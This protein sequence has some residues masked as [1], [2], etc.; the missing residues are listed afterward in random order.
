MNV[1][2]P[3]PGNPGIGSVFVTAILTIPPLITAAVPIYWIEGVPV[4]DN[5]T[6][7]LTSVAIP[8]PLIEELDAIPARPG[9]TLY[10]E[11]LLPILTAVTIPEEAKWIVAPAE[12]N[13]C[14]PNP[15]VDPT[16]II[17]P[18][19]GTDA[20]SGS[21]ATEAAAPV[22]VIDVIPETWVNS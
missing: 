1:E 6:P 4:D 9:I 14:N 8:T 7:T 12:T 22:N 19:T 21:Y 17:L 20:V 2:E 10:P 5:A 16:E 11:P 18:L 3:V 15:S 13:G